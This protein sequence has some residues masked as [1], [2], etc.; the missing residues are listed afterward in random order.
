[1]CVMYA[2]GTL[3]RI[4]YAPRQ[5]VSVVGD[6]VFRQSDYARYELFPKGLKRGGAVHLENYALDHSFRLPSADSSEISR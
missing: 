4:H 2:G 6:A 1:M 5:S 3:Q